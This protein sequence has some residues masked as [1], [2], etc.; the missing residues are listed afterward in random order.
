MARKPIDLVSLAHFVMA[1][2]NLEPTYNSEV[3]AQVEKLKITCVPSPISKDYQDLR[4]LPWSS[5][6]NYDSQDLDQIEVAERLPNG[7]TCLRVGIAH[8]D[9]CVY[10]DTPVDLHAHHNTTSIYTGVVTFSMLPELLSHDRTSLREGE[11]REAVVVEMVV[12]PQGEVSSSQIYLAQ[13]RNHAKLVYEE[14][15]DFL[16]G[17]PVRGEH[18]QNP[19]L[20]DQLHWQDEVAVQLRKR[21][22]GQGALDLETIE[23]RPVLLDGKIH[24]LEVIS[25]NR[26]RELIEDLMIAANTSIAKYL[27]AKRMPLVRRVVKSP[28]RWPRI[29][30]VAKERGAYLPKEPNSLALSEFLDREQE[31]DPLRF[32]DL[33]LTIVKLLGRGEY[34][35]EMP[36]ESGEGHFGL[37]IQDYT[38][39]TAPNRRYVDL[40]TQRILKACLLKQPVPYTKE[41]LFEIARRCTE[42]ADDVQKVERFMRKAAAALLLED[43]IGEVFEAIVTGASDKGTYIR[44]LDPP[45]EGRVVERERGM[46]VGD[47]VRVKLLSVSPEQG[48]IDFGGV[49]R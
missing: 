23:A 20:A 19:S 12:T 38:H 45:A 47:Q 27:S 34:I 40:V 2:R 49:S 15:A 33:S 43:R 6:D 10:Q 41:D 42:K 22:Y 46:D 4:H 24:H 39:S 36:G 11:D 13:V 9:R 32:P 18:F 48:F 8:V 30:S 16:E 14:V 25:K 1:E 7:D 31:R 29:V 21:R 28:S 26:A 44:L 3:E 5:I 37:A 17:R 35:V